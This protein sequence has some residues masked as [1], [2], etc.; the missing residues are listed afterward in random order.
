MMNQRF[1]A[2]KKTLS[3]YKRIM[4]KGVDLEPVK[5]ERENQDQKREKMRK[6]QEYGRSVETKDNRS[7]YDY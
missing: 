1:E 5:V 2:T 4:Q 3:D 7:Q 6:R